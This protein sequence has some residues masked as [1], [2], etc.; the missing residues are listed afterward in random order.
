MKL[1][2]WNTH[3]FGEGGATLWPWDPR[4]GTSGVCDIHDLQGGGERFLACWRGV[5]AR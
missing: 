4:K 3:V 1:E 5:P 2:F